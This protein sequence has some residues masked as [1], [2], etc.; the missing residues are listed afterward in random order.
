[1]VDGDAVFA[2]AV[3]V[4]EGVIHA[5]FGGRAH[6]QVGQ[7]AGFEG[8]FEAGVVVFGGFAQVGNG[9]GDVRVVVALQQ[10]NFFG[11]RALGQQRG[12]AALVLEVARHGHAHGIVAAGEGL[13]RGLG[14]RRGGFG[15]GGSGF[16]G[17][18]GR[19][20]GG[21][22]LRVGH[23][24]FAG[25]QREQGGGQEGGKADIHCVV[26]HLY[27]VFRGGQYSKLSAI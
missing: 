17:G 26:F 24:G 22:G 3:G 5:V 11:V 4:G 25:G 10:G 15:C 18:R 20:C 27:V 23:F 14:G 9:E 7:A 19:R 6:F 12:V 2:A 8:G 1:M 21:F 13:R 16:G